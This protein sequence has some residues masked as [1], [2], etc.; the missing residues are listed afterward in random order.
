MRIRHADRVSPALDLFC[1]GLEQIIKARNNQVECL[2]Y[3]QSRSIVF[4]IH[5][6]G[7]QMDNAATHGTLAGVYSDFSHNIMMNF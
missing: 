1:E 6:S 4:D 7:A 2:P 3:L 5:R